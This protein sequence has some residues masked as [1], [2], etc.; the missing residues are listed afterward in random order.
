MTHRG[1]LGASLARVLG[2][3]HA[4]GAYETMTPPPA[5]WSPDPA[6]GP[7]WRRWEGRGW[8][9][10]TVAYAAAPPE[11]ALIAAEER[12]WSRLRPIIT[13]AI[14]SP[15]VLLAVLGTQRPFLREVAT[16]DRQFMSA[17]QHGTTR[18]PLP[19][20][21]G[22]SAVVLL[23]LVACV[24][25]IVGLASW[26]AYITAATR[27]AKAAGYANTHNRAEM[28]IVFLIPFLGPFL[29]WTASRD[30]LPKGHEAC[31]T[32]AEGWTLIALG[33][34]L[35][36]AFGQIAGSSGMS[37]A[38]WTLV[39]ASAAVW[40]TAA[41]VLPRGIAAIVEDHRALDVRP[42]RASS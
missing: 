10:D 38:A 37:G 36:I 34:A 6:G 1:Y 26:F 32:L 16:W 3:G 40:V 18:P 17:V 4:D 5:G 27:V 11:H 21:P 8:G 9:T 2:I 23:T 12:A 42:A 7:A 24:L 20:F 41:M 31:R 19:K 14:A 39:V 13:F 29:A 22:S 28:T 33:E 15:A 30:C 35:W 25:A